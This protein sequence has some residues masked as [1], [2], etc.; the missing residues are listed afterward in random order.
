[1]FDNSLIREVTLKNFIKENNC[2]K[3]KNVQNGIVFVGAHWCGHCATMKPEIEKVAII[4][5]IR[6]P[7][8]F[9]DG[10]KDSNKQLLNILGV[11]GF[12]TVFIIKKNKLVKYKGGRDHVSIIHELCKSNDKM[13]FL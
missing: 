7:V 6:L 9:V 13:C 5:G 8:L 12:P 1:M 10:A 4:G 11:E 3:T 2:V